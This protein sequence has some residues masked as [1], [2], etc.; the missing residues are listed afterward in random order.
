LVFLVARSTVYI[1][2]LVSNAYKVPLV[3]NAIDFITDRFT[4]SNLWASPFRE[5]T[6]KKVV[7]N[8]LGVIP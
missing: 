7:V 8:P 4:S 6:L 3:S 5:F 1:F 2:P